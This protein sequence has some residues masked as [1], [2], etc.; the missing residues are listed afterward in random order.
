MIAALPYSHPP[1]A[2]GDREAAPP[3]LSPPSLRPSARHN[4]TGALLLT[5]DD[6]DHRTQRTDRRGFGGTEQPSAVCPGRARDHAVRHAEFQRLAEALQ[7]AR[8]Q[9]DADRKQ[10]LAVVDDIAPDPTRRYGVRP[11]T[12]AQAIVSFSHPGRCR[13]EAAFAAWRHQPDPGRQRQDRPTPG[14]TT[15]GTEP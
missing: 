11:V 2:D 5:G 9:L 7:Q 13:N 10:L 1:R 14:S 3:T 4:Q 12:A 15:A 8:Y 6:T